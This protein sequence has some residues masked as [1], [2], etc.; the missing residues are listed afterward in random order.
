MRI[1]IQLFTLMLI[2]IQLLFEVIRICD[3]WFIDPPRLHFEPPRPS[4]AVFEPQKLFNLYLNADRDPAFH[5]T[6]ANPEP[7]PASKNDADSCESGSVT[8][9][10]FTR[11]CFDLN[12]DRNADPDSQACK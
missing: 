2:R 10:A 5:S 3:H 7:D 6:N 12:A 1:R 4:M 9:A 8:L 11:L